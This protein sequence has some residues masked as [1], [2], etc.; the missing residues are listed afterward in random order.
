MVH[1]A[2]ELNF[3]NENVGYGVFASA[4]IPKGTVTYAKDPLEISITQKRYQKLK[5][6]WKSVIDKYSYINEKGIMLLSWDIAK[7]MNH[8]CHCNTMS[9][10]WGFEIALRDINAGE[11]ITDEY[12]LFNDDID[13]P[14]LC[15]HEDCRG[16]VRSDDLLHYYP[17]WDKQIKGALAFFFQVEQPLIDLV[18]K[19]SVKEIR[20]YLSGKGEY[21]SVLSLRTQSRQRA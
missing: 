11:E 9:T 12:G 19:K 14:L 6:Q 18:S 8:C 20:N 4:F 21:K 13:M 10:G 15:K 7:Y 5:P 2:T 17:V 1:P 16:F 3:V